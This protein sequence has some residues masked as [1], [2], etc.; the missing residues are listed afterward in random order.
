MKIPL[1]P[2]SLEM[3]LQRLSSEEFGKVFA[4]MPGGPLVGDSYLHWDQLR[5]REPPAGSNHE[6]WWAAI[7]MARNGL[8]KSVPLQDKYARPIQFGVPDPVARALHTIDLQA[9]GQVAMAQPVVSGEDRDRYLVSSLVEEA[10][11]SSQLE[12]AATTQLVAKEMLRSGRTPR[13]RSERMIFN[14]YRAMEQIHGLKAQPLTPELVLELHRVVTEETLDDPGAAGRL[15]RPGEQVTVM[16]AQHS[17]VLHEPPEASTLPERLE[18]LCMFANQGGDVTPFVHPV[19]RAILLHFM[20]GYDHPFVDGNGRTARALFY[21]SMARS[22]YWL[23]E[24][25][26]ISRLLKQAPAQYG[27][28]YLHAETD[29][30]DATYFIIHQLD[31]IEKAIAALHEYLERKGQEQRSAEKLLHHAP[32]VVDQLN[33]RQTALLGHALRHAG[34]SYTIESH[35]HSHQ[36]THQ[37]ARTDLLK[38]VELNFLE[39]RKRGRSFVFHVPG[40]LRERIEQLTE[41]EQK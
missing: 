3:L 7:R 6:V 40:D 29:A 41:I 25:L 17:T 35:R 8:L 30:S 18:R 4:L 20:I 12:G 11:T 21:W 28:A 24:Y 9:A 34:Y 27:R 16:D 23:M 32:A 5:H 14:N 15:R 36:V 26:S 19:V 2:P 31:V 13:D 10:I 39:Q 38:L 37:T 33:H 22:G 1:S